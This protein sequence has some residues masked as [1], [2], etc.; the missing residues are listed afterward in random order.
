MYK[1]QVSPQQRAYNE[2]PHYT[3]LAYFAPGFVKAGISS[4]GRGVRRLLDQGARAARVVGRFK[5]AYAARELEAALCMQEGICETMRL[6]K[7]ADLLA[8]ARFDFGEA[9]RALDEAVASVD[10][11]GCFG[12]ASD[13]PT[14]LD[15][16][17]E[18]LGRGEGK[19]YFDFTSAYFGDEAVPMCDEMQLADASA[20]VCAGRCVGMVGSILV[21]EQQGMHFLAPLKDWES[22][23]VELHEGEVLH[24]YAVDVYKRQALDCT[25]QAV[26]VDF[27][28]NLAEGVRGMRIGIVPAFMEARG[29]TAE[30]KA[31]VEEAADHLRALGAD[32]VEVELPNAQAAMS[33]YYVLGPCEAFSNLARFDSVRYGYCDPGHADLGSQYEAS[34]AKGFGPETRRR[35]MLG[36]YLLS[37]GVYDTYYYPAQQVRTLITQ[38][39]ERAF[40]RVDCILAPVSPR[41]A[42]R[43]GEVSDPTDMY[44]SDMFTISINIAGNGG[45]SLPAGLGADTGL[46]VGV[47]LVSPQFKDENMLRVAA[48]LE[49]AYGQAPVAPAFREGGTLEAP[50]DIPDAAGAVPGVDLPGLLSAEGAPSEVPA[51]RV[52]HEPDSPAGCP[53]EPGLSERPGSAESA[54]AQVE[55][56]GE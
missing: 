12:T 20:D 52:P 33:A 22:H 48:A 53:C 15:A 56:A 51:K 35:I 4:E 55:R 16:A 17:M 29:L 25:S 44:L 54:A 13:A 2:Q 9:C 46:P 5:N 45:M 26:G 32:I 19:A 14:E 36:S 11:A 38:D 40:Q 47:Q 7:K 1:R 34:R 37:A 10:V 28:A 21:L 23:V 3:Y 39:Y 49:T 8:N 41:T 24:E 30:V 31:K 43:F 18:R 6:S 42:F 27:A 50:A